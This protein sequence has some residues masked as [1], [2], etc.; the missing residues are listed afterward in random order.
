MCPPQRLQD[1]VCLHQFCVQKLFLVYSCNV[2]SMQNLC[3]FLWY[4][5]VFIFICL[6]FLSIMYLVYDF[7]NSNNNDNNNIYVKKWQKI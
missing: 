7:N 1:Y 6:S 5:C 3:V 4:F 2:C